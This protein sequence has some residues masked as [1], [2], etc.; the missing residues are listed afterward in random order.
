VVISGDYIGLIKTLFA[1]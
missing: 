1:R